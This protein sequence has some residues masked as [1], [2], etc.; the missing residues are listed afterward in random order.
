VARRCGGQFRLTGEAGWMARLE[1]RFPRCGRLG[2]A[3]WNWTVD[4]E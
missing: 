2:R 4:E 1:V 3:N